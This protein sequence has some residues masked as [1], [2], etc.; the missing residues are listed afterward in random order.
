MAGDWIKMRLDLQTHPKVVRILSATKADKFRVVGGLHAVW[1]VFD[2]HSA[3]GKLSGYTPEA[4]DHIIGWPGFSVAMIAVE[5]LLFDGG[6]TLSLPEWDEHNGKSGKRRA[7]DQKRKRDSRNSP[8][9]V[10]NL[11]ADDADDNGTREEKRREEK[12]EQEKQTHVEPTLDGFDPPKVERR[13]AHRATEDVQQVFDYWRQ[14]MHHPNA[15]LDAK[16]SK[17]IAKRLED[18]FTVGQLCEAVDGCRGSAY[19]MGQNASQTVYDD[20]E[21]ICRDGPHAESFINRNKAK[22]SMD[23]GLQQQVDIL[24]NWMDKE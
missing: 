9:S 16:R 24:Q 3:D 1:S 22:G 7:E 21:L 19:H 10:R 11:S 8:Q 14:V 15:R 23:P 4:M 2:T 18:G 17:A 20:I 13:K 12:K 5:W 6:E